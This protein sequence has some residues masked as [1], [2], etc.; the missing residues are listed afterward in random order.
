MTARSGKPSIDKYEPGQN[1]SLWLHC[2]NTE[3][4]LRHW[5]DDEA[6]SQ[7]SLLLADVPMMWTLGNC[8]AQRTWFE[9][10]NGMHMK[11]RCGDSEQTICILACISHR[12]QRENE[13]VRSYVDEITMSA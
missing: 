9:F 8:N 12:K 10:M 4:I 11:A 5:A 6:V 2:V 1:V 3:R 13:S 7:A